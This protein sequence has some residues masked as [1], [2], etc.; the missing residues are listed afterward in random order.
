MHDYVCAVSAMG[1]C[2]IFYGRPL[3]SLLLFGPSLK[4]SMSKDNWHLESQQL[5]KEGTLTPT[6]C[7]MEQ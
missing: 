2:S 1:H 3:A 4:Q 7:S 5:L 6:T